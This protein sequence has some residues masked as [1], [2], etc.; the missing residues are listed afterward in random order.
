LIS[1]LTILF[2]LAGLGIIVF[3]HELGHFIAAKSSGIGVEVFSLG[4]GKKLFGFKYKDTMYQISVFPIG[5][6]CKMKGEYPRKDETDEESMKKMREEKGS[7]LSASPWARCIVAAAGP[8]ANIFFAMVVIA[9]IFLIGFSIY[10]SPAKII[11]A[12]DYPTVTGVAQQ[13][14]AALAGLKT[15][16]TVIAINNQP[17]KYFWDISEIIHANAGKKL[18][19]TVQREGEAATT[20]LNITVTP[21]ED[22]LTGWGKIGITDWTAPV[23]GIV[24]PGKAAARAGLQTGDELVA[25]NNQP[26]RHNYDFH[27][28]LQNNPAS[29]DITYL[30]GGNTLTTTLYIKYERKGESDLG[31]G[32]QRLLIRSPRYNPVEAFGK[33]ANRVAEYMNFTVRGIAHIFDFKDKRL[34]EVVAGPFRMIQMVGES[35]TGN[36]ALGVGEGITSFF[37][38][39]SFIS[40]FIAFMNLIPIPAL[41]GG[42]F[43]LS[44]FEGI[45]RKPLTLKSIYRFQI[46]GFVIV[47]GLI[48]LALFSEVLYYF[49]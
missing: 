19:F 27:T 49:F 18:Q 9:L 41:D 10:T 33:G 32:F 46:V 11:L 44:A 28:H 47:F 3:I 6:Y 25:I 13:S 24:E 30:R 45:R 5:G 39:I 42:V 12:S 31:M 35:A 4:W 14:P 2:G 1:L 16:D 23:I 38:F 26:V 20:T 7:Y 17:V 34:D 48:A 37:Q 29:I 15:G 8:L 21:E 22:P 43:V 36:L 40:I